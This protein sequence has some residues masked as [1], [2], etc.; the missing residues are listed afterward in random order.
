MTLEMVSGLVTRLF[1]K[2]LAHKE[3]WDWQPLHLLTAVW[4]PSWR[5][6]QERD[7]DRLSEVNR[8]ASTGP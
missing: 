5:P 8:R 2:V 4:Q 3:P 6:M 7:Y 1:S